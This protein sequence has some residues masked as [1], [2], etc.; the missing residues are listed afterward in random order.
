MSFQINSLKKKRNGGTL[1][2]RVD[3]C[4]TTASI[5]RIEVSKNGQ[6]VTPQP[7][8]IKPGQSSAPIPLLSGSYT[9]TVTITPLSNSAATGGSPQGEESKA[10]VS[11][12]N[13]QNGVKVSE[14]IL[15]TGEDNVVLE[16]HQLPPQEP[17]VPPNLTIR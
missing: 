9:V 14:R 15:I 13:S 8:N 5:S 10:N 17:P 16:V 4:T 2:L 7:V 11:S 1:T 12:G 6:P 3:N